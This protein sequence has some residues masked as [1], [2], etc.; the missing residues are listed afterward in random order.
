MLGEALKKN[1]T[2][3]KV[4][5]D[6]NKITIT[7]YASLRLAMRY[8]TTLQNIPFPHLDFGLVRVFML[9]S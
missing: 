1:T 8:N 4:K 2:L 7:G 3:K 9:C 6:K 5:I